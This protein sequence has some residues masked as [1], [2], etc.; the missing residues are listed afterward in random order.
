MPTCVKMPTSWHNST[1]S[2]VTLP[3]LMNT[4]I[5]EMTFRFDLIKRAIAWE[6]RNFHKT[7]FNELQKKNLIDINV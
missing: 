4:P 3:K 7:S 5:T 6:T 2:L 1:A